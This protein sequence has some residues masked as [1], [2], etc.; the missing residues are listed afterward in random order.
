MKLLGPADYR[1]MPWKNGRG[2]TRELAVFPADSALNGKPF[3]WRVS[4]AD[5]ESDCEFSPFPGYDRSL[6]LTE[7]AGMELVFD[8][9]PAVVIRDRYAPV[10]LS[11]DWQARC[12][13]L[14]GALRDFNVMTA[15]AQ[16]SHTCEAVR[17]HP[18]AIAW[19]PRSET[20]MVYCCKGA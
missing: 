8:A 5:V 9:A 7:G 2:T 13:L 14:N 6:M 15:R 10:R 12:R 3:A 19:Q 11:G 20:L 4:I 16:L 1:I 17:R 18:H